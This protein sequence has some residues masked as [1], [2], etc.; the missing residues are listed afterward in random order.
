M[1]TANQTNT[2]VKNATAQPNF[3]LSNHGSAS[4]VLPASALRQENGQIWPLTQGRLAH[5]SNEAAELTSFASLGE[6]KMMHFLTPRGNIIL[7]TMVIV[8]ASWFSGKIIKTDATRCQI[9]RL[10][11]T[12]SFVDWGSTPDPA[13]GAYSAPQIP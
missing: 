6:L 11:Y 10:K 13:E 4:N 1:L 3:P 5:I 12:K 9:L 8:L 2:H 7:R